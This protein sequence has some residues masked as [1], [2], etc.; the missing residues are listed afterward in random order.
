MDVRT[1]IRE[2]DELISRTESVLNR[3]AAIVLALPPSRLRREKP[4]RVR[5]MRTHLRRLRK[6]RSSIT[7]RNPRQK[8][9]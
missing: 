5:F 1:T 4:Q 8:I 2:L 6:Q 7:Q 3:E 9:A